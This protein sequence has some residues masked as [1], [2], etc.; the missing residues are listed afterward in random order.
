M[1]EVAYVYTKRRSEFGKHVEFSNGETQ[2]LESIPEFCT[3]LD[4]QK[5]M[6]AIRH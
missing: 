4:K 6:E 2:I 5:H 1:M 3:S